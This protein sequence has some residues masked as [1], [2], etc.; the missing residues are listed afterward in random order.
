MSNINHMI[1]LFGLPRSGTTWIGKSF[2][3]HP[4][5]HYLHE[6]D[7]Q[8]RMDGFMPLLPGLE[9]TNRYDQGVAAYCQ[10]ELQRCSVR[11]CG[12]R[13]FFNKNY[14]SG[15]QSK[16]L[17]G[18]VEAARFYE[19]LRGRRLSWKPARPIG[20]DQTRLVWKSIESI[21]R[22][23]VMCRLYPQARAVVIVRD[24]RGYCASVFRGESMKK[25]SGNADAAVDYGLF[26]ILLDTPY[27]K[28]QGLDLDMIKKLSPAERMTWNWLLYNQK[29]FD[30]IRQLDNVCM[31]RYEDLCEQ[32]L[33]GFRKLFE[34]CNLSFDS[35]SEEFIYQST[36]KDS[37]SYYS[38]YKDPK[39]SAYKW[40]KD[41]P[42]E[43]A[44]SLERLCREHPIGRAYF[45]HDSAEAKAFIPILP[46]DA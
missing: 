6:P 28:A 39:S 27:A 42:E 14:L 20:N 33:E 23:G 32:P 21:G 7:T 17:H 35:Q 13:P 15:I 44:D 5:V 2:D 30:D 24:P 25:F 38:V 22:T 10:N 46:G 45:D 34:F 19:R 8:H 18:R 4:D 11:V 12:K 29:V 16:L 37:D 43:T 26:E 40:R 9:D 41:I 1:L 36:H 3:S 31:V